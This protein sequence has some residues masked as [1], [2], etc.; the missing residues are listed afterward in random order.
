MTKRMRLLTLTTLV[1]IA[2]CRSTFA[3]NAAHVPAPCPAAPLNVSAWTTT[4]RDDFTFRVPPDFKPVSVQGIDSWVEEFA[5]AD[6]TQVITFDYGGFSDDLHRDPGMYSEYRS[7]TEVIGAREALV[8]VVRLHNEYSRSQDGTYAAGATWRDVR[9][10]NH[11]TL[12]AWTANPANLERLL[13]MLR[14]VRFPQDSVGRSGSYR[15]P[16]NDR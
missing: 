1:S 11:L 16:S 7:C 3:P 14:T 13:A 4:D 8:V 6:S 9:S 5:T 12:W 2:G 15:G 10:G